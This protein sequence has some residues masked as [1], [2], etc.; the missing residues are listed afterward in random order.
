MCSYHLLEWRRGEEGGFKGSQYI[1]LLILFKKK[2]G[3]KKDKEK[4]FAGSAPKAVNQL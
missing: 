4:P 1:I 3:F 2:K